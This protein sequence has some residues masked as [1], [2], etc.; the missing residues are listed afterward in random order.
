MDAILLNSTPGAI[1]HIPVWHR[2]CPTP[3]GAVRTAL[4]PKQRQAALYLRSV[5]WISSAFRGLMCHPLACIGL[6]TAFKR[7]FESYL[8]SHS[9]KDLAL[10]PSVGAAL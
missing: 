6:K 8:R 10:V 9:F 3:F 5:C 2:S 7:R 1:C 4:H